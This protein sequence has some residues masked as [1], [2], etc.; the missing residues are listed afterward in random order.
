MKITVEI[1]PS[2]AETEVVIRAD[3][4]TN[5]V[6]MLQQVLSNI[7]ENRGDVVFYKGDTEFYFA[8]GKILFFETDGNRVI[9]HTADEEYEVKLK[10]YELEEKLPAYFLRVSKSTILNTR[11]V[12]GLTKNI[13]ASSRVDFSGTH[14][15]VYVSRNYFKSLKEILSPGYNAR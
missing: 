1:D 6:A 12:Y 13:T 10:L 8:I 9:A 5:E 11:K 15:K 3:A 14:K 2:L 7:S 4:I